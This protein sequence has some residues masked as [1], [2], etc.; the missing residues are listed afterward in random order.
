MSAVEFKRWQTYEALYGP[1]GQAHD[2]LLFA[3]LM[4]IIANVFKGEKGRN[5]SFK[6][7]L[8]FEGT[9]ALFQAKSSDKPEKHQEVKRFEAAYEANFGQ[10]WET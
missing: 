6:D 10:T 3:N 2:D 9:Q 5:A 4:A 1:L 7:F 8:L